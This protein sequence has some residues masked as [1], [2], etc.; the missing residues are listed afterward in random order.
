MASSNALTLPEL[1]PR[2]GTGARAEKVLEV[3]L[4]SLKRYDLV[5]WQ[6]LVY[7]IYLGL[8]RSRGWK[9]KG[10]CMSACCPTQ[11]CQVVKLEAS[12]S[13]V[14][15]PTQEGAEHWS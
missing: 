1:K 10:V 5:K 9:P 14:R 6:K 7:A 11:T 13:D 12:K 4:V 8:G 15:N 3:L 2:L